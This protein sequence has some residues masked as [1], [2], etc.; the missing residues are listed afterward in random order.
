MDDITREADLRARLHHVE[1]RVDS[2]DLQIRRL[3]Q[4]AEHAEETVALNK[5]MLRDI[6]IRMDKQDA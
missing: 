3:S 2:H 4:I 6:H 5:E 1:R